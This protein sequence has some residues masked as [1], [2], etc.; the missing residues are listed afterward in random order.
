MAWTSRWA[1][2]A[3]AIYFAYI[4]GPGWK[5]AVAD[6]RVPLR[7]PVLKKW[8]AW[9]HM[10]RY[11]S[12]RLVRT[13]ELPPDGNYIFTMVPHGL[14]A[15]SG[16]I[17]FATDATGFSRT[18]PGINVHCCTLESNF[19]VPLLREYILAHGLLAASKGAIRNALTRGAG[20]SVLL[21][22][23]GA[24]EALVA[25]PGT[26]NTLAGKRRGF[27]HM[28]LET[29]ASI[30]PVFAFGETDMYWTHI[31]ARGSLLARVLR[32]V[33]GVCGFAVVLFWGVGF[34]H[35]HGIMPRAVPLT[36][37]VGAPIKVDKWAGPKEGQEY[38]DQVEALHKQYCTAITTL[39]EQYK[40]QYAPDRK[41]EL[42]ILSE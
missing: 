27:V 2:A 20:E 14:C 3:I 28:A 4:L 35:G 16:W 11:F 39:W 38:S 19:R 8:S 30:V 10:A 32:A 34:F 41:S 1:A 7:Q 17:N 6:K 26:Y 25:A 22:P 24:A 40:D 21:V 23:G 31:P 18:F 5:D 37:V 42:R 13:A 29:G 36:T 9:P 33:K 12:A 15:V